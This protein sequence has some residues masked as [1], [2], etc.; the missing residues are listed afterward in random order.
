MVIEKVSKQGRYFKIITI[1]ISFKKGV[2]LLGKKFM[3][4]LGNNK[5]RKMKINFDFPPKW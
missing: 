1:T 3:V 4:M 5:N 2:P